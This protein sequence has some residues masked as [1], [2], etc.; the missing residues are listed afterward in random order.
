MNI[1]TDTY[2][3]H[4]GIKIPCIGYGT[5]AVPDGRDTLEGVKNAIKTGYRNIDTAA[6]YQNERSVGEAIR[7]AATEFG[8]KRE[9]L[10]IST[11]AWHDHRGYER[12]LQAFEESMDKLRLEYLDLYLI[13]WPANAKWHRDWRE[14]NASTWKALE[15]LYKAGRIKAIGVSNFL[16]HHVKALIED[17]EIKPMVN[18]IE[19]HPGFGQ[20][21]SA[22]YC[23]ANGII[24]EAWSPFGGGGA[25]VLK[26]EELNGIAAK[27]GKQPAQV[28]LRWL[29]QKQIVPL[30]KSVHVERM[31]SNT[32]IFDFKLTAEDMDVIDHIPYCGGY[33]FDPDTA[34]S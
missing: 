6:A 33:R 32:E 7:Q 17:S 34:Q 28:T 15:E 29:L 25:A 16:A 30:P 22:E 18:Q 26:N 2:E 13:H 24:V 12:T 23:Q 1:M 14:L 21:E 10:F 11:K 9:D 5:C 31:V 20:K 27:Y 4:N 19:Y 8:V 3:L